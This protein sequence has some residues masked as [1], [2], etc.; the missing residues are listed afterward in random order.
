MSG[1]PSTIVRFTISAEL[2]FRDLLRFPEQPAILGANVDQRT[3]AV[4]LF[5]VMPDAPPHAVALD[6]QYVRDTLWPD[7]IELV[8]FH[9]L[10]AHGNEI[11]PE[12]TDARETP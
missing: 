11:P 3:G 4:D 9:W 7:P 1:N 2:L 8:G 10:D 12:N 6:A 5:L